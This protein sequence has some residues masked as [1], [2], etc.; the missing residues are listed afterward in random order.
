MSLQQL[1]G[2]KLAAI[3][4][5]FLEEIHSIE[6]WNDDFFDIFKWLDNVEKEYLH[7]EHLQVILLNDNQIFFKEIGKKKI[8]IYKNSLTIKPK[9]NKQLILIFSTNNI[10]NHSKEKRTRFIELF[11]K[12]LEEKNIVSQVIDEQ[13]TLQF[14]DNLELEK[15]IEIL[16]GVK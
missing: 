8:K 1:L 14:E 2:K 15:I 7:D 12:F 16:I 5:D 3:E 9:E 13:F 6:E 4:F 11:L 10:A